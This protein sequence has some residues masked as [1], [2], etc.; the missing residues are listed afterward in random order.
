MGGRFLPQRIDNSYRGHRLALWLFGLIVFV[1]TSIGLGT[2]FN[3]RNAATTA[4]GIALDTFTTDGARAFLSVFAIWGLAQATIGLLCILVLVRYRAMIPFMF[5]LLL[6]EHLTRKLILFVM[7]I[8]RT[9]TPP[10]SVINLALVAVMIVGLILSLR[11]QDA[12]A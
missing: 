4:D 1:K 11:H 12:P 10:G 9:G 5:A 7:P 8:P 3:G 6:L 2:I